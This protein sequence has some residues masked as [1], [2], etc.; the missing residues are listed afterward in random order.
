MAPRAQTD[1]FRSA[2][3]TVKK[4]HNMGEAVGL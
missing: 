2:G 3:L 4:A 1:G